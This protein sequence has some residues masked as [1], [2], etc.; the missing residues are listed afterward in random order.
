M[1]PTRTLPG[2][3]ILK[4]RNLLLFVDPTLR[5]GQGLRLQGGCELFGFGTGALTMDSADVF[6]G[7]SDS[8][9]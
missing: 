3:H 2:I 9:P 5:G 6:R 7:R 8:I 1:K 4:D